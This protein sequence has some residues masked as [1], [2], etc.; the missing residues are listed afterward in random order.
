M[1]HHPHHLDRPDHHDQFEHPDHPANIDHPTT[2]PTNLTRQL[3]PALASSRHFC[4]LFVN[5]QVI[6]VG[7]AG[8]G[9]TSLIHQLTRKKFS[10]QVNHLPAYF[11]QEE[12][13]S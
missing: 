11:K 3:F 13:K 8:V 7:D 2:I 4:V 1:E 9:K 12:H 10:Q 6:V 5:C